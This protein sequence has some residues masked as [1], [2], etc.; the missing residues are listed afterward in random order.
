M[1]EANV[2]EK[3]TGELQL[4]AGFS[5]IESFIFQASVRQRNFRG[6]GQTVGLSGSYS[7]YTKSVEASFTE[8][9]LFDRNV[10]LGVDVYR[11][12]YRSF[13]FLTSNR[14]RTYQQSTTG[15]QIRAGLP[16]NEYLTAVARYT[17]NYD[18]ITLDRSQFFY[19]LDGDGVETCEPIL[20]GR[21]LCEAIGKR[22]SSILGVSLIYD[23][24][25]NRVRPT[26]GSTGFGQR[27]LCR[28]WADR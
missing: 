8:P 9:Y 25:D 23:R 16:L 24:L 13:R 12:D 11:R 15:F 10:S 28:A 22:T 18:D 5:S 1:L 3:P 20:A 27:G 6:R 7:R 26:R 14:D 4:S 19:D 2:E 21:Y 17:L